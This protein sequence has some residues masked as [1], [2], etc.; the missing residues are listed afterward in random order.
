MVTR[1]VNNIGQPL[2]SPL[3]HLLQNVKISFTLMSKNK[4]CQTFD[5]LTGECIAPI[6][7]VVY[8]DMHGEFSVNLWCTNRG[9]DQ[10]EYACVIDVDE[11]DNFKAPLPEGS[12]ITFNEFQYSGTK[13]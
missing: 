7:V 1:N 4:P 3:G 10:V 12:P 6:P 11:I 2:V 8:T 13:L 9:F 5:K